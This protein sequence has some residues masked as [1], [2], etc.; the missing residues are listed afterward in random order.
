[1]KRMVVKNLGIGFVSG[2]RTVPVVSG[3]SFAVESG[4]VL[5]LVGESGCGKS[6]SAMPSMSLDTRPC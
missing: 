4:Q 5:A 3:V 1:M 6:T 2:G